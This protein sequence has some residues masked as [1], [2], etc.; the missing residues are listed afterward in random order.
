MLMDLITFMCTVIQKADDMDGIHRADR[1]MQNIWMW[2]CRSVDVILKNNK[3]KTNN[4]S[5]CL[6][7]PCQDTSVSAFSLTRSMAHQDQSI[8]ASERLPALS[9]T[10]KVLSLKR[11]LQ[12]VKSHLKVHGQLVI[13]LDTHTCMSYCFCMAKQTQMQQIK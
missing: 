4:K 11:H 12:E 2:I 6:S 13:T 8:E 10:L 9:A 1:F 7:T 5:Q 3:K